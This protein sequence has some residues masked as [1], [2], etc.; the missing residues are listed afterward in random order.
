M[1]KD[2]KFLKGSKDLKDSTTTNIISFTRLQKSIQ[3]CYQRIIKLTRGV[4]F[5][6]KLEA[7]L[8]FSTYFV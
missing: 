2:E 7:S 1:M 3:L 4:N 5:R 6:I 8:K